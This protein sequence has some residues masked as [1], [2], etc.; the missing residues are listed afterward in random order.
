M[1]ESP[2]TTLT[3]FSLKSCDMNYNNVMWY[4]VK[5][6]ISVLTDNS[7]YGTKSYA[8][9][10][11]IRKNGYIDIDEIYD[12]VIKYNYCVYDNFRTIK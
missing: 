11:Y 8:N 7:Q 10:Q 9:M 5:N 1:A 6:K 12:K 2:Q 3:L 4:G